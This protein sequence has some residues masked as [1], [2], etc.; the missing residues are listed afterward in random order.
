MT[1]S[2]K[3]TV[4]HPLHYGGADDPFE[5]I[6]VIEAWDLNFSLGCVVKYVS[7]AGKKGDALEDLEKARWY[8]D[9]EIR[10]EEGRADEPESATDPKQIGE[11]LNQLPA[12]AQDAVT[13]YL[14]CCGSKWGTTETSFRGSWRTPG[15]GRVVDAALFDA[16]M[17][18]HAR[19][20]VAPELPRDTL[21][22]ILAEYVRMSSSDEETSAE[23]V[24]RLWAELGNLVPEE[25]QQVLEG[26]RR[27]TKGAAC[28]T[29]GYNERGHTTTDGRLCSHADSCQLAMPWQKTRC[30][31]GKST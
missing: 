3:E 6:K 17:D 26:L 29:C 20:S 16:I 14:L 10:R 19:Y 8:L 15:R 23:R 1:K 30:A 2:E 25:R 27:E 7:R 21:V 28:C 18:M 13:E 12:E 31:E 24:N 9:R 5:A 22:R 11:I 4:D